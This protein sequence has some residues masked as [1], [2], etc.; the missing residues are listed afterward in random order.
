MAKTNS[1]A[2]QLISVILEGIEE[3]KGKDIDI[4]DLRDIENTR[5]G[6]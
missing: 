3:V 4:L 2:D 5:N 1:N 6:Y